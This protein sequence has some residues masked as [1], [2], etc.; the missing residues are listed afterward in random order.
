M[1]EKSGLSASPLSHLV[2]RLRTAEIVFEPYPHYYLEHVFPTE[3]YQ[4]LLRHLPASAVYENYLS[5]VTL[6]K[7]DHF[8]HR[9]QR[10]MNEDWT[11]NLPAELRE[12]WD[13]FNEWF[14]GPELAQA[15]LE[16]FAAPLSA[17]FGEGTPWPA[18]SVESRLIRHRA[19]YSL[20]PHSDWHTK[21]VVLLIYLASDESALHL[22][23]SLYQP[24]DRGF[25]CPVSKPHPF[26]DFVRVKTFPY[27]P[28][29]LLAF[30]RSDISF[31]GVEPLSEQDVATCG[32][33][34][35]QY[36]IHDKKAR[37]EDLRAQRLAAG[38]E[39]IA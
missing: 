28:N 7:L 33:D 12:F 22:G 30:L 14:L 1:M 18:V 34:L 10:E 11:K 4:A 31:H 21:I 2:T 26:E 19:G 27:K 20:Q 16:S 17:R 36:V 38:N 8:Q 15:A 35:I 9:V 13:S 3:Y 6:F 39:T 29:S 25:S 32:R 23:T 24:K 5:F 37:E